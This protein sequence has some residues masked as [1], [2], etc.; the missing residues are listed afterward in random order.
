[1]QEAE[2]VYLQTIKARGNCWQ[3]YNRLG[4]FY[5]GYG[6]YGEAEREFGKVIELAPESPIGYT[7]LGLLY[8]KRERGQEGA[9]MLET[10]L[11]IQELPRTYLNLGV[12]Y[13]HQGCYADAARTMVKAVDLGLNDYRTWG[14]L[15]EAYLMVPELADRA[16]GAFRKA[17]ALAEEE[18]ARSSADAEARS[19]LSNYYA[20][21]QDYQKALATIAE[22]VQL[23][24]D[25]VN[26]L[27]HAALV[28][29]M[30]GQR[31]RAL[32]S[33]EGALRG[34]YSLKE[35]RLSDNLRDLRSDPRYQKLDE[36]GYKLQTNP[37]AE[38]QKKAAAC[39]S[40]PPG[41]G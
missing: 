28:Y 7:N 27:F 4:V 21:L 38:S 29:E 35:I 34:G 40:T 17:I 9:K 24:P 41:A 1:V 14:D 22:A 33:I 36:V 20:R 2:A 37:E 18:T 16:P 3:A 30:A 26:V 6:R 23:G 5:D 10:S 31:D 12:A 39:P 25:N 8:I 15:A 11:Q 13:F 19:L 32:E